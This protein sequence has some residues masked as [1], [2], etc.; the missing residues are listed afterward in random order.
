MTFFDR[1]T[2]ILVTATLTSVVWIVFGGTLMEL[3]EGR[4]GEESV[5]PAEAAPSPEPAAT[6]ALPEEEPRGDATKAAPLDPP[7]SPS[8]D[9]S[10][11]Q[12]RLRIPVMNVSADELTDTFLDRRGDASTRLHEAIDIMAPEGTSIVAAAPGTIAKLHRSGAGGNSIYVRSPDRKR[13]YYYAHLS[14][15]AEGLRE[16]QRIREGQRLGMVGSTGNAD[17]AAP[18]LHFAVFET[19]ADAE[20]WEPANAVNPYPLLTGGGEE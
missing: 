17:P 3:A 4:E 10:P 5:R 1:L 19:T 14:D 18:H 20:W 13:I 7:P 16:G 8:P 11:T 6:L 2:T 9:P 15:Y 12:N